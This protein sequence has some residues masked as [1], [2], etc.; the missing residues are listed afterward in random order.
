MNAI[1]LTQGPFKQQ[2][3]K[4]AAPIIGTSFIQ[5]AYTFTDMAWVGHLGSKQLAAISTAGILCWLASTFGILTKVGAETFVAQ[6]LGAGNTEL[7]KRYVK[8]NTT[9]AV[10]FA[11][12]LIILFALFG[13]PILSLYK[14]ENYIFSLSKNYLHLV[15]IGFFPAFIN[16]A[17][18]GS[19]NA[20]GYSNTPFRINAIGLVANMVLD[21]LFIYVAKLG[22]NGAAI[23]TVISQTIVLLIFLRELRYGKKLLGGGFTLLGKLQ[24]T[25]TIKI[26]RFGLPITLLSALFSIISYIMSTIAARAGSHIGVVVITTG[27]QL[28]AISWNTSD[29]LRTALTTF[30]AQN[31]AAGKR[32]RIWAGYRFILGISVVLGLIA[33]IFYIF[34]G[35]ALFSLITNDP[36]AYTEGGRYFRISGLTQI[37]MMAEITTQG[38]FYGTARSFIPSAISIVGNLLRIPFALWLLSLGWGLTG[39]WIVISASAFIKGVVS[40][41]FLPYLKRKI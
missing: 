26:L 17:L 7:A 33:T 6:A 2:L 29:G 3:V 23:A 14:L 12:A 19:Y 18:T 41:L 16:F 21:P 30:V 10:L 28:E 40:L 9:L 1:D 11:L 5:I 20:S 32:N 25:E 36:L 13:G 31:Y 39:I 35:E 27:G 8:H 38:L 37:F 34:C 15:M 22:T 4:L 24:R